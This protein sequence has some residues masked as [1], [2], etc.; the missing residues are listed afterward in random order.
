MGRL[1]SYDGGWAYPPL[2]TAVRMMIEGRTH[3]DECCARGDHIVDGVTM[4]AGEELPGE[5][6]GSLHASL[7][8]LWHDLPLGSGGDKDV[9]L[10]MA[11]RELI[12]KIRREWNTPEAIEARRIVAERE[13][14][15]RLA[16]AAERRAKEEEARRVAREKR[17]ASEE[18][19]AAMRAAEEATRKRA[20]QIWR[21][22]KKDTYDALPMTED[23]L[24]QVLRTF[25]QIGRNP[26]IL[27]SELELDPASDLFQKGLR[28]AVERGLVR[29]SMRRPHNTRGE[30]K[31]DEYIVHLMM[32]P[33]GLIRVEPPPERITLD[34]YSVPPGSIPPDR[35]QP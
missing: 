13:A 24:D 32:N 27:A 16:R 15:E 22:H 17:R 25:I 30:L 21:D 29:C 28:V 18:R 35:I 20:F 5:A 4:L 33:A 3:L 2:H 19:A 11:D 7:H 6:G 31:T 9:I 26:A 14:A 8:T 34:G 1:T 12:A 10:A 23:Q